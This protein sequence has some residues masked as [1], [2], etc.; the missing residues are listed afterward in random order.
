[1]RVGRKLATVAAAGACLVPAVPVLAPVAPVAVA[2]ASAPAA[3]ASARVAEKKVS[4]EERGVVQRTDA[5]VGLA[6]DFGISTAAAR[7]LLDSTY[8]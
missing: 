6:R 5:A 3:S 2:D 8:R 4:A 7:D 1:M